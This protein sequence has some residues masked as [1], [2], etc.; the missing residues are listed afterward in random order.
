MS[1]RLNWLANVVDEE[2]VPHDG[3][4]IVVRNN[5]ATLSKLGAPG[6]IE[7]GVAGVQLLDARHARVTFEDG[8]VW[9][10]ERPQKKGCGC[11]K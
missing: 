7:K 5:V 3:H 1:S 8:T 6:R 9:S 10:V 4:S 2:G 11:G